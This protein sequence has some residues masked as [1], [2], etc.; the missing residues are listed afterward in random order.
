M[1]RFLNRY[2]TALPL[3]SLL[4]LALAIVGGS[5]PAT[6]HHL[7]GTTGSPLGAFDLQTYEA[8]DYRNVYARTMELAGW[9]QLFPE[10]PTFAL[11]SL[12]GVQPAPYVPPVLLKSIAWLES[13]WAQ[14]SYDPPVQYGQV[15]PV[16]SS[17]D[18]GYGI[19]QVT[20]GMQNVTGIPTLD[21]AMIGGHYA[22]N[23]ARGARILA[24]KWNAAPESQPVVGSRNSQIIEDWYYALWAYN[25]FASTNHPLSYDPNRPPYLCDGTQ[26]RSAYPYQELVLGC[27]AHPPVRGGVPL[28]PAQ[29]V[30]LPNLADP[31]FNGLASWDDFNQC[32][33]NLQCAGMN[34]PTPNPWHQD[35]TSP[36]LS[37]SQVLG[38]PNIALSTSSVSLVAPRGGLSAN[39]LIAIGNGGSGLLAWRLSATAP[40]VRLSRIQGVSLGADLGYTDHTFA[41]SADASALLP[42]TYSAQIK[43]ESLYAAG[44]PATITVTV[45]TGDGALLNPSDG[46]IYLYQGGLKRHIPDPATFEAN[47]FSWNDVISVPADWAAGVPT[48]N[49]LPSVLANGRLLRP[50]G[51]AVPV[52]V[53][54]NGAKRHVTDPTAFMQCGYGWDAVDIVSAESVN[55]IPS[56]PAL[57]A[58]PCPR[59]S[60]P[61]GTLL[62]SSDGKAWVVMWNARKWIVS[63]SAFAD[64]GY[65]WGN[66]NDLGDSI[67]AQ[68]PIS[69]GLT[70]CTADSSLLLTP[71][72][73]INVVRGRALRYIP[74]GLTFELSGFGW[75]DVAPVSSIL[76]TGEAIPSLAIPGILVRP[77]GAEVPIYVLDGGA[78]RH[79]TSPGVLDACGY[80]WQAVSTVS[81]AILNGIPDGPPL[82]AGPCP[83]LQFPLGTLLQGADGAV[84][85]T[86]GRGRKWV[87]TFDAFA[88]CGYQTSKVNPASGTVLAGLFVAPAVTSCTSSNSKVTTT[89]GEVY[90]VLS[91]WKRYVPSPATFDALGITGSDL[92]PIPDGWLPTANPLLDVAA[93]GR[94]VRVP[95]DEV[96]I[97]VMDGGV[98]RH[99][100]SPAAMAACA[101]GWDAVSVLP[102]ATVTAFSEGP[103]LNGAPCPQASFANGTLLLGSDGKVWVLQSGQRRWIADSSTFM[104][105]GYR[106]IDIDR[107]GDSILA[108]LPQGLNLSAPPCP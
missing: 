89:D 21:Q 96:P 31:A 88:S 30:S 83:T 69:P 17:H 33:N 7:C 36:A 100:T 97:Y 54:E 10:Y 91:G 108:T 80:P 105:C 26:P 28:W 52:Y 35:P 40:W 90:V 32:V 104:A 43:V 16:L 11:P 19:M 64:C 78:K 94:L 92:I 6:A 53:M 62:R 99:I 55:N 1:S 20:S 66:L 37:R 48:G 41:V 2:T 14:A 44:S 79:I 101:Y 82:Q 102:A 73:R 71:D 49:P 84:W 13:G 85:V 107:V 75:G 86:F 65:Q 57:S 87:T 47:G 59:P 9:N 42:G 34:I 60:F 76:P 27:V 58:P 46:G 23:I 103:A 8:A 72:G 61:N 81:T 74:D 24:E 98:K 4:A 29:D 3:L 5:R 15:G 39:Q 50:P 25:G 18:C 95:G 67:N 38:N 22:F 45:H 93:T 70:G 12:E 106:G 63:P 51:D 77:P 68:L 56:G